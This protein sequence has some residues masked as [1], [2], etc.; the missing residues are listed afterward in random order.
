MWN[1]AVVFGITVVNDLHQS[2]DDAR[3]AVS[4][5]RADGRRVRLFDVAVDV[6]AD[7]VC[8]PLNPT[9]IVDGH[10]PHPALPERVLRTLAAE[11]PSGTHQLV[12]QL[13]TADGALLSRGES[14]VE[15][16]RPVVSAPNP[17]LPGARAQ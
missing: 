15:W 12:A 11:V 7:G 16:V 10:F 3:L 13:T 9:G 14:V 1:L 17:F 5:T 6:P 8:V 2:F 4:V